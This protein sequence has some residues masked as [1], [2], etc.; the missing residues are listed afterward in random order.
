[1]Q[2]NRAGLPSGGPALLLIV[3]SA[4]CFDC[5]MQVRS[6]PGRANST[7]RPRCAP[8]VKSERSNRQDSSLT[9]QQSHRGVQH[10]AIRPVSLEPN[11]CTDSVDVEAAEICLRARRFAR[12]GLAMSLTI[13][14]V[15]RQWSGAVA[16]SRRRS[17]TIERAE[18]WDPRWRVAALGFNDRG[19]GQDG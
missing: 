8:R 12:G 7:G 19:G 9:K 2:L 1:M 18:G 10:W 13:I 16:F 3:R 15:Q 6:M 4:W 17:R 14:L 11:I 5:G